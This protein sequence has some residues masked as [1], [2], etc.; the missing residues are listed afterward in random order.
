MPKLLRLALV[1]ATGFILFA[2]AMA[3][4]LKTTARAAEI[5]APALSISGK[6]DIDR[7]KWFNSLRQPL[8]GAS[9]CDISDCHPTESEWK[10][11]AWHA[12]V[13]GKWRTIPDEVILKKK[14]SI[15]EDAVVCNASEFQAIPGMGASVRVEEPRIYCFVP[16]A[17][18]S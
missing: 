17:L 2:F 18:G 8:T 5:D 1:A 15:L 16:P 4:F 11:G 9:C 6:P 10:D 12:I 14:V 7:G 13:A 3:V